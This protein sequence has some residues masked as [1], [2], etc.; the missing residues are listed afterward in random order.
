[1]GGADLIRQAL[2]EGI[3]EELGVSV[4]PVVLG[5]GKRLFDGF[6]H[7]LELVNESV[8]QSPYATHLW[9]SVKETSR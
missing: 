2:A 9:F 1:M 4:A 7:D 3:V 5:S 8:R 6:G